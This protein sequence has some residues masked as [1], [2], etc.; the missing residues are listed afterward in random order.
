MRK[1][2]L[3]LAVLAITFSVTSCNKPADTV[4]TKEA[5]E[6]VEGTSVEG[7]NTFT[8]DVAN[9]KLEWKGG[10]VVGSDSHNGTISLKSGDVLVKDGAVVGG[11]FVIDMNT[12]TVLDIT[13]AEKKAGLEGHLK[14][15]DAENADHFFNVAQYP[16]GKFEITGVKDGNVEGNLTLKGVTKSVS[17]PATVTVS[18]NE[19]T[20]VSDKF[21]IDRT[22]WN[23][24]FNNE[25]LTD[26]AKDKVI[27]NAIEVK[28]DVKATK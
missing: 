28:V 8:A 10:K 4:E 17:F 21:N 24:N 3:S 2:A 25:S 27:S 12:I 1:I 14:G 6:V 5:T 9:S 11:T 15:A 16:E 23:V 7:A 22:L 26:V 18:E 13:D 20:I 19:V